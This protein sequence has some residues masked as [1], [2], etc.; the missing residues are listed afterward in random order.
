MQIITGPCDHNTK[1]HQAVM[2]QTK[3]TVINKSVEMQQ[4]VLK[5]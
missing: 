4:R 5:L 2:L 3:S 1:M